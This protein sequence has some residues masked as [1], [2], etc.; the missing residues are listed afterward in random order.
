MKKKIVFLCLSVMLIVGMMSAGNAYAW[1]QD[2]AGSSTANS[3]RTGKIQ[4]SLGTDSFLVGTDDVVYPEENLL[5]GTVSL[6]NASDISTRVRVKIVFD[7]D[8]DT[9]TYTAAGSSPLSVTFANS[10]SWTDTN[11]GYFVY[12]G[13]VA[14]GASLPLFTRICYSGPNT[15]NDVISGQE[16]MG[17]TVL[18]EAKQSDYMTAN[19]WNVS[20][21]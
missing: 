4:Y 21:T 16:D 5:T 12:N 10:G 19:D 2:K 9:L 15:D 3:V 17:I 1:F 11:D 8:G 13:V 6:T 7:Y 14:A 18:Y 20:G